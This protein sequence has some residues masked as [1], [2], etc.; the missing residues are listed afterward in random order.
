MRRAL[1]AGIAEHG[2]GNVRVV[3][4]TWPEALEQLG[5]L[6][7]AD[8]A[9][10]AHVGYD[11]EEIGPFLDGD[12][13][14]DP[15]PLRRRAHGP[16]PGVRGGPVLAPGP[17]RGA[18]GA[19]R[20]ARAA[21]AAPRPR[22]RRRRWSASSR[23]PR[24]FDSVDALTAFLRRQL[25][26]TEGGDK[27]L[28]FRAV[29]PDRIVQRDG[30]WTLVD[31]PAGVPR[32]RDLAVAC[33]RGA[34]VMNALAVGATWIHTIAIVVLLGYYTTLS[35]VVLPWLTSGGSREP[36][37][38]IAAV[39]RRA[40][41]WI[42][43][44]VALFTVTGVVL[45]AANTGANPDWAP[46]IIVKHVIVVAMIALGVVVDRVLVPR[47]AGT[48]WTPAVVPSTDVRD[49]RPIVQASAAMSV[50]G[51]VVLLLTAAAQLG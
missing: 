35:L 18:R 32:D 41:P 15:G 37:S 40:L 11:I 51:A 2:I 16:Q 27:D 1:R 5:P 28:H 7:A 45:M 38:V 10:I 24:S 44:S 3:A 26:I 46:L 36:G 29:L 39:E 49:L 23:S 21:G 42:L 22:L 12:G 30:A 19:A 31:R 6:P 9:L 13:G 34:P 25:F 4:G 47:V 48:W 50:L 14:G 17:R 43:A 20:V 33:V 8:V